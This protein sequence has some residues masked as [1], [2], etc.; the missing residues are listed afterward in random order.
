MRAIKINE[1]EVADIKVK[2]NKIK[3][4]DAIT[5]KIARTDTQQKYCY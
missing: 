4:E 1:N 3:G 2:N 5:E